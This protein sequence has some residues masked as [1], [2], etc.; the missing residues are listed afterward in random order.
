MS[1]TAFAAKWRL[2]EFRKFPLSKWGQNK[3]IKNKTTTKKDT[4]KTK[5]LHSPTLQNR[6]FWTLGNYLL[7]S[8]AHGS[9]YQIRVILKG[10]P[11]PHK[12]WLIIV[13]ACGIYIYPRIKKKGKISINIYCCRTHDLKISSK[14][15]KMH[16]SLHCSL[17]IIRRQ[18]SCL[19]TGQDFFANELNLFGKFTKTL[20]S[21]CRVQSAE[22]YHKLNWFGN[23]P[24]SCYVSFFIGF[25]T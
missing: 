25:S 21:P 9:W 1:L 10:Q 16:R 13:P 18:T 20:A 8:V 17:I 4:L 19:F 6:G 2:T 12:S 3:N 5:R 14:I 11:I 15:R 23:M 24:M 22:M 7:V